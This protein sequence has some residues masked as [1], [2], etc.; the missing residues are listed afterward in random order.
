MNASSLHKNDFRTRLSP[1]LGI[2]AAVN[3]H[4]LDGKHPDGW[5]PLARSREP[6]FDRPLPGITAPP[7]RPGGRAGRSGLLLRFQAVLDRNAGR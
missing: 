5:I 1:L 4:T 6:Q 7:R 2:D 3:R